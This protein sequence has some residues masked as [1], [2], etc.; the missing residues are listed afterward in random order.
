MR[1]AHRVLCGKARPVIA[2][3]FG[4]IARFGNAPKRR[5]PERAPAAT[6]RG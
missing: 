5:K 2:D 6:S 1:G 4:Q 3:P